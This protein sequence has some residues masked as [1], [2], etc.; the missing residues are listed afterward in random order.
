ATL[1]GSAGM[2][3][4]VYVTPGISSN[5]GCRWAYRFHAAG[6]TTYASASQARMATS[7]KATNRFL[8]LRFFAGKGGVADAI[9]ILG[10]KPLLAAYCTPDNSAVHWR[11]ENHYSSTAG[12]A[13]CRNR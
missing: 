1:I 11:H 9:R 2:P 13:R 10:A 5:A 7:R 4:A 3:S 6:T 12:S 8:R